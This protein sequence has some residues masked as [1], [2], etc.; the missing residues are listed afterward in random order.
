[1]VVT[2]DEGLMRK[3]KREEEMLGRFT[4]LVGEEELEGKERRAGWKV[5]VAMWMVRM[6]GGSL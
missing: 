3:W 4:K 6:A 5:R 2:S 1:M